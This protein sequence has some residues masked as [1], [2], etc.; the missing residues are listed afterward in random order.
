MIDISISTCFNIVL[1]DTEFEWHELQHEAKEII[2]KETLHCIPKKFA[3]YDPIILKD[4]KQL[5]MYY[6]LNHQKLTLEF[7]FIQ[8]DILEAKK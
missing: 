4:D 1:N 6:R 7:I 5:R 3:R 8:I 2:K